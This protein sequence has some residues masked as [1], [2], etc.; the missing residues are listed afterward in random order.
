MSSL[1]QNN[2]TERKADNALDY[3]KVGQQYLNSD[4]GKGLPRTG[5]EGPEGE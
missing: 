4:K 5:H 3:K 1:A 2:T